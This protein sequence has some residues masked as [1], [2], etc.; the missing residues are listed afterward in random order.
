MRHAAGHRV[1][2]ARMRLAVT[3]LLMSVAFPGPVGAD[4]K[5]SMR[6]KHLKREQGLSQAFVYSILQDR[7][8]YMWFGTQDGLNR[9]DGYEFTVFVHE[10]DDPDSISDETI[11]SMIIDSTGTLWAGTDEGGLSRYNSVNQTFTN[12]LHDPEDPR[13]IADNRVRVL[14]ENDNG[15]LWVGTDGSGLDLFVRKTKTFEHFRHDPA[16]PGSIAGNHVWSILENS[17][18]VLLVATDGGVSRFDP[19]TRTFTHFTHDPSDPST[20]SDNNVRVLFEDVD[21]NLWV[22]T[23]DGG[24]NRFDYAS[25]TFTRF[26]H[27]PND[28]TSISTNRIN[29]IF[30]DDEEMLWIGTAEGLNLWNADTRSFTNYIYSA[31]DRY[32]L[33]NNNVAAIFQDRGGILWLGTYDG[34]NCWNPAG[35]AMSL[36]RNDPE[37]ADSLS[38]NVVTAF[39]EDPTGKIW[40]ATYGGGLN[41]LDRT[42]DQLQ[43]FRYSADDDNS[44]SSDRVMSVLVDHGGVLWAGTRASGLSRYD[45]TS[46]TFTR[47]RHNPDDPL[48]VSADGITY[49]LEDSD[50][51]LWI[52][53]FGGGLNILNRDTGKFAAYRN[54]PD[55]PTTISNDRVLTIHEDSN[56][57]LWVGTYGGGLS[58]LD[59][60]TGKFTSY[61]ADPGRPDGLSG[62]EIY[63][64]MEDVWGDFWIGVKGRGLNRWRRED[65]KQGIARFERFSTRHGLPSSTIYGAAW[66]L[67]GHLWLSTGEGLSRLNIETL[68]FK[69]F[70]TSHGLQD[71]EFNVSAGYSSADGQLFFGG[72]NGFNAFYP[73]R[74]GGNRKPPQVA[75]TRFHSLNSDVV[76]HNRS[77]RNG[78]V[79]LEYDENV[80]AF[81]FA[82]L[83][84][85]A[86]DKNRFK[87]QLQG[88]D[89]DWVDAGAKHQVTYTNLPA[90]DYTFRVAAANNNGTWS[91]QD[92]K[93]DFYLQPAP[94]R[95]G[96]AYLAYSLVFTSLAY[97]LFR[98]H[99]KTVEQRENVK[100][101]E[102]LSIIQARLTDAQRI[103]G[104]GNWEWNKLSNELWWSDEVYR[105]FQLD[106]RSFTA[107]YEEFLERVHPEDRDAVDHAIQRALTEQK[108]YE[109]DHRIVR[110]DGSE[111][112]VHERAEITLGENGQ[113]AGLTGTIHDISARKKAE[114]DIRRRA[115]FQ[116]LLAGLSTELIQSPIGEVDRQLNAS[117]KTVGERYELDAVS[118][119]WFAGECETMRPK[120]RWVRTLKVNPSI[121]LDPKQVPWAVAKLSAGR[122][123]MVVDTERL[124]DAASA[125]QKFFR[126]LGVTSFLAIPLLVDEKLRGACIYAI[127]GASRDWSFES[128]TELR[129]IAENL[130][131][132]IVRSRATSKIERL[133]NKLQEEN[134]YLREEVKLAHGFNEIIGE[135]RALRRCLQAAEKV[136]PTDVTALILGETGTGKELIARAIHRLSA[137][138]EKPLVSVN[139]PALPATLIESELF[140]HEKGAF[141]GAHSQRRGRF[142]LAHTGTLFLDEIGELPLELQGK[143]LRVLQTGEFQRIGGSSTITA[144]VR[145]IAATNLNLKSAIEKGE[146]RPDLYYRICSFPISLPPLRERKGD[147]PILAEHFVHKH[148]KRLG[149]IV[150]GISAKM[151]KQLTEYAWPGNVREL[152]STIERALISAEENSL[153]EL[154]EPLRSITGAQPS[155]DTRSTGLFDVERAHIVGVLDQT[156]WKISGPEGAASMLGIPSSTLRSKM[157]KLSI[158]RSIP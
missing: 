87:Y 111:L 41:L 11:R 15:D 59:K 38:A 118:L 158:S 145:L 99:T 119:W 16:D 147:I 10:P 140:G 131:G 94:W 47:Y 112:V 79:Q 18:G 29:A 13:S 84:F 156:R 35:R 33:S 143:L 154:S 97:V 92:A 101:A 106:P 78:R 36:Y 96:W 1:S 141:T 5:P 132:A 137:R 128:L 76:D 22:G 70:N 104:L 23:Q 51:T 150:V 65:R 58:S 130:Q 12:F 82:A 67:A 157:K 27:D 37:R 19:D 61:R 46:N 66:D 102:E 139:C 113:P 109:I 155:A 115:D 90:G 107:T 39:S 103:A 110:P 64:I 6:F 93:F 8:G 142:E 68:E 30:Q 50:K 126:T 144:D 71:D 116:A 81:E 151:I 60:T 32:S 125:D 69:N 117:L 20:I 55:D 75:I 138:S 4:E 63:V 57:T 89:D 129:L 134:L 52:G 135:D 31:S 48:S 2:G 136:A 72:T 148:R 120:Y 7:Q 133:K 62:D 40:V 127:F 9:F 26:V 95:T 100:C 73:H 105:L 53:T 21:K 121:R 3:V 14:Y 44:L 56:G 123:L 45:K 149:K 98:L 49:I 114:N 54:N 80:V 88:L 91:Q 85:V 25:E 122:S 124:P 86:P 83:D 153:L 108:P 28:S 17:A 152:E 43:R 74:L 42:N 24:L 34:L 77:A 146:F